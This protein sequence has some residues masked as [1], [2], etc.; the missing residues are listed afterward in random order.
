MYFF[1][2]GG[3][4]IYFT[5]V[6]T[7]FWKSKHNLFFSLAVPRLKMPLLQ[8]IWMSLR[9]LKLY[10]KYPPVCTLFTL[11]ST[12]NNYRADCCCT[13]SY[14]YINPISWSFSPPWHDS[15]IIVT[16]SRH[17]SPSRHLLHNLTV[18][19]HKF[20]FNGCSES[21]CYATLIHGALLYLSVRPGVC[22][23]LLVLLIRG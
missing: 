6:L 18:S 10:R 21:L 16:T 5:T 2:P 22:Y 20:R 3:F 12:F 11:L 4:I 15:V 7:K 19:H 17:F 1:Q 13:L 9:T 8:V 14:N 23:D